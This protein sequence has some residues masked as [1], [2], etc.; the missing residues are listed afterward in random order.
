MQRVQTTVVAVVGHGA[1]AALQALSGAANVRAVQVEESLAPLERAVEAWGQAAAMH[2]P[3]ALHDA[4]PLAGVVQAWVRLYDGQGVR[5]ELEV[6][7]EQA[8]ERWRAKRLELPDYY[9]VVDAEHLPPT[10]RHWYL[11]V[12]HARAP[13]RLLPTVGSPAALREA[14][15]SRRAGPW[16]PELD[17]LLSEVDR[18]LPEQVGLGPATATLLTP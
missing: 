4:D 16:W 15:A 3:Y 18:L 11:G 7:R 12:L 5:G 17:A 10:L 6:A 2:A 9:L 13:S 1:R 14:L 8:L